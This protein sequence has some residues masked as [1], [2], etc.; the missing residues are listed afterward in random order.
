MKHGGHQ[1][2]PRPKTDAM[3]VEEAEAANLAGKS[4]WWHVQCTNGRQAMAV[5][6]SSRTY[7]GTAA[8]TSVPA[9][10]FS[11]SRQ[12][13][14]CLR[15]E[16]LYSEKRPRDILFRVIE[17]IVSEGVDDDEP[18]ILSRLTREAAA[19][20]RQHAE[21][22][23]FDFAPWETASKAVVKAMLYAGGLLAADGQ[24]I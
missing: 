9:S 7:S 24:P 19:R 6:S 18:K 3:S 1:G 4:R 21:H 12:M 16:L 10:R 15:R 14:D 20:A 23:G 17:Q 13:G 22:T 5:E 2:H 11:R 8:P